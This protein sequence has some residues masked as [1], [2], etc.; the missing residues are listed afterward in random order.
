MTL[1]DEVQAAFR[2]VL[3]QKE[4][5][6]RPEMT[7]KDV[8]GWDSLAHVQLMAAIERRLGIRFAAAEVQRMTR[9]GDLLELVRKKVSASK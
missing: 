3:R 5:V 4:L 6:L 9:V 2:V 1:E 8:R 7:A